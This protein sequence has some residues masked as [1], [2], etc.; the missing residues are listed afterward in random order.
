MDFVQFLS[1]R[2]FHYFQLCIFSPKELVNNFIFVINPLVFMVA[3]FT[4]VHF[5]CRFKKGSMG[6]Q[7][8]LFRNSTLNALTSVAKGILKRS[9]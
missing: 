1:L 3:T 2:L 4:T 9:H 7:Q 8:I 5:E 6:F